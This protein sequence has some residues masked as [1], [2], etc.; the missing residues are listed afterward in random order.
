VF[1]D[2]FNS[3]SN[4]SDIVSLIMSYPSFGKGLSGFSNNLQA[5]PHATPHNYIG[6]HMSTMA[7]PGEFLFAQKMTF[8]LQRSS[9]GRL[10]F[11]S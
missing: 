7:S 9:H 6:N 5:K 8:H 3:F 11:A 4:E 2:T 1:N 10:L